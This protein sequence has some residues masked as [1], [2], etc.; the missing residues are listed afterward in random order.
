[1]RSLKATSNFFPNSTKRTNL[2]VFLVALNGMKMGLFQEIARSLVGS[3]GTG[4]LGQE[5]RELKHLGKNDLSNHWSDRDRQNWIPYARAGIELGQI[6]SRV[7][8]ASG[9]QLSSN[10]SVKGNR[11]CKICGR[12]T[13]ASGRSTYSC[14]N[15]SRRMA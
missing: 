7:R 14:L 2:S 6:F 11:A 12:C 1:M 13:N 15:R 3:Y 5:L 10:S 9:S 8:R 4:H